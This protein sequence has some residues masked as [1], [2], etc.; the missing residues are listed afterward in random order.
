MRPPNKGWHLEWSAPEVEL[1]TMWERKGH[2]KE[3]IA[4]ALTVIFGKKRSR[5]AVIGK[6]YRV[7]RGNHGK[8]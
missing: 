4:K 3:N 2:T 1:A 5:N 6:M 7:K 8:T